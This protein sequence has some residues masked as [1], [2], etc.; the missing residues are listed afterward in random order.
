[1]KVS[2]AVNVTL[3]VEQ[4]QKLERWLINERVRLATVVKELL[5]ELIDRK[6]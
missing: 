2:K 1:M 4:W 6:G 3:D 5:D